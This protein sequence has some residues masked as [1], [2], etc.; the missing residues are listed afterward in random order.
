M[1]RWATL[2]RHRGFNIALAHWRKARVCD[3][4]W[5]FTMHQSARQF[6]ADILAASGC[7]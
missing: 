4:F 5:Q 1:E 2:Y 7:G 6:G 3:N